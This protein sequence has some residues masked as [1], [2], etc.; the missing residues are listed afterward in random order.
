MVRKSDALN[1]HHMSLQLNQSGTHSL[2]NSPSCY[3]HLTK[4]VTVSVLCV[5]EEPGF[6]TQD[7]ELRKP[8]SSS[9]DFS[10]A[11]LAINTGNWVFKLLL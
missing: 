6:C 7:S 10:W 5:N 4:Q 2:T 1:G 9:M 8:D 3:V 11:M